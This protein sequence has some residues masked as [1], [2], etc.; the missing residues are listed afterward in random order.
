MRLVVSRMVISTSIK[1]FF[2]FALRILV[3]KVSFY[4]TDNKRFVYPC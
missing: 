4:L 1:V 2:F 3:K